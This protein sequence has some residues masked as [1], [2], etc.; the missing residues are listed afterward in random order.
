MMNSRNSTLDIFKG[1]A[2]IGVLFM[3]CLFPQ[4]LGSAAR[5]VGCIGVPLFFCISGYYLAK[6]NEL[7]VYEL[8]KKIRHIV[9]L[10]ICSEVFYLLFS[11]FYFNLFSAANRIRLVEKYFFPG[12]L[13]RFFVLNQPPIYAHLW[14]LYALATCYISV[15]IFFKTKKQLKAFSN[16]V[17]VL[18][19]CIVVLQEFS[20]LHIIKNGTILLG[21]EIVM[22]KSSFFLFRAVP[23]FLLGFLFREYNEQIKNLPLSANVLVGLIVVAESF[24]IAEGFLFTKAQFYLGNIIA[25]F[26]IMLLSI[27]TPNICNRPLQFLGS[28]LSTYIYILHIAVIR[29]MDLFLF[30]CHLSKLVAIQYIRPILALILTILVS[31]VVKQLINVLRHQHIINCHN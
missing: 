15:L 22:L 30:K 19:F 23:F 5:S 29:A 4:P 17:P 9:K 6:K 12:T 13:A 28:N 1:L 21:S 7:D 3:H 25:L 31:M 27:K 16:I 26:F 10:I 20:F 2:C 24:A 14:F 11:V 18:L 8:A